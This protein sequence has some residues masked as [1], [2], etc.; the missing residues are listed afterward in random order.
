[1]FTRALTVLIPVLF[2]I[3]TGIMTKSS[4]R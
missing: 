1:L 2:Y 4:K 3:I